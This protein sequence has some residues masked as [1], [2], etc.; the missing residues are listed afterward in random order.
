M[1][2][3]QSGKQLAK[4]LR[5]I[6]Q[7]RV[8]NLLRYGTFSAIEDINAEVSEDII[9]PKRNNLFETRNDE[10]VRKTEKLKSVAGKL[11]LDKKISKKEEDILPRANLYQSKGNLLETETLKEKPD[12]AIPPEKLLRGI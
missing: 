5:S 4:A 9:E 6:F 2:Q 11:V 12:V 8:F 7:R 1:Y 3:R 10:E